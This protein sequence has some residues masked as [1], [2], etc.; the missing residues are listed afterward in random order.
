VF[1]QLSLNG[2]ALV[3]PDPE[4]LLERKFRAG[5]RGK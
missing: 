4:S 3:P 5:L 1:M 2:G